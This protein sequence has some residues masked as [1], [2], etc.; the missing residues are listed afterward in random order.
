MAAW[1]G[2]LVRQHSSCPM[3]NALSY[4][5]FTCLNLP[6]LLF[7][8]FACLFACPTNS[9]T[10]PALLS[11]TF[12]HSLHF[13]CLVESLGS[14]IWLFCRQERIASVSLLYFH[15]FHCCCLHCQS[16][17]FSVRKVR[18]GVGWLTRKWQLSTCDC[19]T[20]VCPLFGCICGGNCG[21]ALPSPVHWTP[22]WCALSVGRKQLSQRL[23]DIVGCAP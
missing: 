14:G 4:S 11:Q 2:T 20:S 15:L 12:T 3:H 9:L 8:L 1:N 7:C 21:E 22:A 6:E 13:N 18:D 17:A 10:L 5:R 23:R 19:E 16:G